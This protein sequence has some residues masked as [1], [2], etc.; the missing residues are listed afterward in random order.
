MSDIDPHTFRKSSHSD[1]QGAC[2]EIGHGPGVIGIRDSRNPD[3]G[4]LTTDVRRWTAFLDAA[5]AGRFD[6]G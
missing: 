4:C 6:L 3:D 1:H 5:K 2:V